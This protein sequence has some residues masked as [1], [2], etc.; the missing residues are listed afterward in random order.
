MTKTKNQFTVTE[1]VWLYPGESAAWHFLTLPKDVSEI[2][3][4]QYGKNARGWGSLP[5]SATIGQTVFKTSIFPDKR[6][7]GYLLPIKA[8]V[9]ASEGIR[10]GKR[11]TVTIVIVPNRK[12]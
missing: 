10:A 9:R 5:V 2:I 7:G 1:E 8:S 6:S 3:R 4:E 12:K 11:A